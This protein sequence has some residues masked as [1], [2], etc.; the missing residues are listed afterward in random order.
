MVSLIRRI[1]IFFLLFVAFLGSV[2]SAF[3]SAEYR[4]ASLRG[5]VDASRSSNIPYWQPRLGLN[6]ELL[7][8]SP[9]ELRTHL[10]L[11]RSSDVVWLRQFVRWSDIEVSE[12]IYSWDEFDLL[13]SVLN[14]YT[15]FKLIAVIIYPPEWYQS[16]DIDSPTAPPVDPQYL[17]DFAAE[18]AQRYGHVVDH[19][20]IW[21]EPNLFD[22]WGGQ[23]PKPAEYAALLQAAYTAIKGADA[24]ATVMAA[25][26]APTVETGPENISDILYLQELYQLGLKD[27]SDGIAGKPYG[28][29][30]SPIEDRQVDPS[31]LNFSRIV[32]LREV[33]VENGDGQTPLWAS[34]WGWNALPSDWAGDDSIWGSVTQAQQAAYTIETLTRVEREFPWLAGMTLQHWQPAL[35]PDDAGWGFAII[36][37]N[38]EPTL[39]WDALQAYQSPA[40]AQNG[41]FHPVTPFAQYSGV[42]TF[43]ELGAD[44]GWLETSDSQL[45]FNYSGSDLSLLMREG[46]YVAF[47]Y[48]TIDENPANALPH[49]N[50]GN[51]YLFLRSDTLDSKTSLIPVA[52][53]LPDTA[54]QLRIITDKG[55]DQWAFAGYAVSS[56]NLAQPYNRQI[57]AALFT[58]FL[59]G[60]G[61]IW[62]GR[63][64]PWMNILPLP[65]SIIRQLSE[66][67]QFLIS[68]TTSIALMLSLLITFGDSTPNLLRRDAFQLGIVIILSGGLVA[69]ELAFLIVILNMLI[70]FLFIYNRLE[71]GLLLTLFYAPFFLFPVELYRF[72]FPMSELL[73]LIT[74]S[75]WIL[76]VFA[77]WGRQR[78]SEISS[79]S[80]SIQQF[81]TNLHP[82]DYGVIAWVFLGFVSLLWAEWRGVA[83]TEFRTMIV[84][85]ALFY[86]IFRS[87]PFN[88]QLI[89]K[90]VDTLLLAG[91]MVAT[92][93][94]YLYITGQSVI[95]A[96]EGTRRLASVY[97]SP[98]NVGLFLGRCIPFALAYS[99]I[100]INRKRRIFSAVALSIML[101]A[102][103][104]TVSVG[105]ILVG[106]PAAIAAVMLIVWK[107]RAIPPLIGFGV[108]GSAAVAV[109]VNVSA[110]FAS[111][112]DLSQGTN[113]IRLR[114]WE[115]AVNII[116]DN[117][118]L[119]LGLD[120]FLYAYRGH[121]IRPDAIWD[122]DLSHP[123]N[124]LLDFWTRLGLFGVLLF[125]YIQFYFWVTLLKL[126]KTL[127]Q[128]DKHLYAISVGIAGSMINLLA[129]GLIDNSV[130]VLDLVFIFVLLLG[131]SVQL[132][133][134]HSIDA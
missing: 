71:Y 96:E 21:D 114:V 29:D 53:N 19:Y 93:G 16:P 123:H 92:I 24:E 34:N 115:S 68:I 42:W 127:K 12:G 5:Y 116:R 91:I 103:A 132:S 108:L 85:P 69:F 122:R 39:L 77:S 101:L 110:R 8:Y 133:N 75:A 56:G 59:A 7:Q 62:A 45:T 94:L 107:K 33:M 105:A 63:K 15:N 125:A 43:G 52:R 118:L 61:V 111:L 112:L 104:L 99:L 74:T 95:T 76:R 26:L 87:I 18:F 97:G 40:I 55:W 78:Q 102:A 28:F 10:D 36:D 98:N 1:F 124:F 84:E 119:G 72:A 49:D 100:T 17:A 6:V 88:R 73:I 80:V 48:P 109:L 126:L 50:E 67:Q 4:N 22:A 82:L 46:D 2:V 41:L 37:Q 64:I 86:A 23:N 9:G 11:I 32:A 20:Q 13:F 113:F 30:T 121:Y 25:A 90:L 60:I 44:I 57:A 70:L 129:H 134:I 106:I 79:Y 47:L 66:T 131:M 3:V 130:F 38:D 83:I 65:I 81:L 35:P 51:A 54:H 120:Q 117:P 58:A 31:R 89:I 27:Y 14:D 128:V